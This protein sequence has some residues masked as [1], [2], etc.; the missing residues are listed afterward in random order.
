M[1]RTAKRRAG[2]MAVVALMCFRDATL[3]PDPPRE[4]GRPM[5]DRLLWALERLFCRHVY[6]AS[7]SLPGVS[8]CRKCGKKTGRLYVFR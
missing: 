2:A 1:A 5:L 8:I 4:R 3:K 6:R 7:K